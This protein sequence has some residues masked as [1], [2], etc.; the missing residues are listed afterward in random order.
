MIVTD[1][2]SFGEGLG[3]ALTNKSRSALC[4]AA[5]YLARLGRLLLF[6]S[7]VTIVNLIF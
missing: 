3:E 5:L 6:F 1:A 7:R 4:K 2:L